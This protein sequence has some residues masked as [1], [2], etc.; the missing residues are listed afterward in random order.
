MCGC[1]V[2]D[3]AGLSAPEADGSGALFFCRI[4]TAVMPAGVKSAQVHR[5]G[6]FDE[7][8]T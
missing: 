8:L 6:L 3:N 2:A 7:V 4:Q 5:H 1:S